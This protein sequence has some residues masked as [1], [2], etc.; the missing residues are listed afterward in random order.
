MTSD[1][2]GIM[3]CFNLVE[4]GGN[5]GARSPAGTF[6]NDKSRVDELFEPAPDKSI[7]H[8]EK[9]SQGCDFGK[10]KPMLAAAIS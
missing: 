10:T 1:Q 5:K 3:Y 8:P 6:T 4:I 2:I 9:V 7:T